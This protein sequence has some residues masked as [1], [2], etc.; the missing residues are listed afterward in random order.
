MIR[1]RIHGVPV[2]SLDQIQLDALLTRARD[3]GGG[4]T[5][6]ILYS[7]ADGDVEV[8]PCLFADELQRLSVATAGTEEARFVGVLRDDLLQGLAVAGEG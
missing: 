5:F 7:L 3:V 1:F 6:P 8:D 4:A 2:G